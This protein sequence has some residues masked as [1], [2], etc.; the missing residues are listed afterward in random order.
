MSNSVTN[1]DYRSLTREEI[2]TLASQGCSSTD[3][4]LVQ[5]AEGFDPRRARN[6][7][8]AGVIRIGANGGT[9]TDDAGIEK[10]CG[11]NGA[12]LFECTIGNNVR[13]AG[14]G[15]HIARYDIGD[16]VCIENVGTIETRSGATFGNRRR[17]GG[18]E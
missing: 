2:E 6:V 14:V 1:V 10:D 13:I 9:F 5:V 12:L 11:I 8:F 15:V 3:W 7:Q 16:G 18:S 17:D 4:D